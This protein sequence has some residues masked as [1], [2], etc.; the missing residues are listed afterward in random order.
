[1]PQQKHELQCHNCDKYVQFNLKE[2][3]DGKHEIKCPNCGHIH[4]RYVRDGK[5]TSERYALDKSHYNYQ[6]WTA[7]GITCSSSCTT[8]TGW[9]VYDTDFLGDSSTTGGYCRKYW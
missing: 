5:V 6:T 9:D 1:M 8:T 3:K 2:D 4:Y 7:I